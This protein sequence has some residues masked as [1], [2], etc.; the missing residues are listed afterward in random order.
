M[1]DHLTSSSPGVN[2]IYGLRTNFSYKR[3]FSSYVLALLENSYEKCA[4][5]MLMKFTT[6]VNFIYVLHAPFSYES[7]FDSFFNYILALAGVQKH[8]R[9][10]HTHI[11]CR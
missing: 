8:F 7:L 2:F 10:K 6:G 11:K 1:G 5:I 3:H 9:T 4:R